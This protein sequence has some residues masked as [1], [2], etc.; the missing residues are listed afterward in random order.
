MS[1]RDQRSRAG[2]CH[3]PEAPLIASFIVAAWALPG[4]GDIRWAAEVPTDLMAPFSSAFA[5]CLLYVTYS[6]TGWNAAVYGLEE[7]K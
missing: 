3:D 2:R 7:W 5:V 1:T 4:K 6:Y